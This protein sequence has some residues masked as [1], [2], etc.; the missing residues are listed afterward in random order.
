VREIAKYMGISDATLQHYIDMEPEQGPLLDIKRCPLAMGEDMP[1]P[2]PLAYPFML[3][4]GG[5]HWYVRGEF[6]LKFS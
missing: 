4:I 1:F 2:F 3:Y 5:I 6:G